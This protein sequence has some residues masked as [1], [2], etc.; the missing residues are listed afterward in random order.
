MISINAAS[1][2]LIYY[3]RCIIRFARRIVL[4]CFVVFSAQTFNLVRILLPTVYSVR[5]EIEYKQRIVATEYKYIIGY[6]RLI[7]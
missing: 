6:L 7:V 1:F 2:I 4:Q 5:R 3:E